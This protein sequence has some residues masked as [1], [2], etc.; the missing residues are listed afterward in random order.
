MPGQGC[1]WWKRVSEE[2]LKT[3]FFS[4]KRPCLAVAMDA[5]LV[6]SSSSLLSCAGLGGC[7]GNG[8]QQLLAQ[9]C[10]GAERRLGGGWG[11]PWQRRLWVGRGVLVGIGEQNWQG[12]GGAP[13]SEVLAV[14]EG[15]QC[16]GHGDG[17]G[18]SSML[19]RRLSQR[20]PR[21]SRPHPSL[22]FSGP[23]SHPN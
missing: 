7:C 14:T 5:C 6:Q 3:K 8:W 16:R 12:F 20:L 11:A 1:P 10:T 13:R 18:V 21:P 22:A 4:T 9:G 2:F 23:F 15:S 17:P 19:S